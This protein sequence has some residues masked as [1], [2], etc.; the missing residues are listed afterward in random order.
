MLAVVLLL[1]SVGAALL[2][3]QEGGRLH[4]LITLPTVAA[5]VL[6]ATGA[7]L[8]AVAKRPRA[9]VVIAVLGAL[10]TWCFALALRYR[11]G[12]DANV[13]MSV[14][15]GLSDGRAPEPL[16]YE[17]LSMYPNNLALLAIDRAAVGASDWLGIATDDL[18]IG[19]NAVGVGITLLAVHRMVRPVAGP[20]PAV[21]GQLATIFL[22]GTSPWMTVPYTDAFALPF[23]AC[24]AAAACAALRPATGRGRRQAALVGVAF[25]LAVIACAIKSTALVLPVAGAL[26]FGLSVA[27]APRPRIRQAVAGGVAVV[28][29]ALA[30]V[31]GVRVM[32]AVVV[33][34]SG[35][36]HSRLEDGA[37][38]P[39]LWW[40][41]NGMIEQV[42]P[43]G[44]RSYGSYSRTMVDAVR[45]QSEQV[46]SD[47]ARDVI[48]EQWQERGA[49][50]TA[51]FYARKAVWNWEDGMFS[52]WGEGSDAK[53]GQ[54][55]GTGSLTRAVEVVNGPQGSA[56]AARSRVA[57]GVWL[58]LL[59]VIALGAVRARPRRDVVLV[60][61]TVLGIGAF[62]LLV[63]GRARYLFS[64]AP[65]VC[66]MAGMLHGSLPSWRRRGGGRR[67]SR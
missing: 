61:L 39:P 57:S 20:G 11:Y 35:V 64:F 67:F 54:I 50:G 58:G 1:V 48:A 28:V 63:Q 56:Y 53:P 44:T 52:A 47:Y 32:S 59:L 24:S 23:V 29:V 13:V 37:S 41:A 66:V 38:P 60:A 14:A 34:A 2:P 36:D 33:T 45:G 15:R 40:I 49:V 3:Q 8:P 7:R 55:T 17:Y 30:F 25:A 19:A 31:A 65:L 51:A 62:T 9:D 5:C 6:L 12:W 10:V 18:V 16:L 26:M 42:S 21:A 4:W 22:V 43:D 46:A 27:S